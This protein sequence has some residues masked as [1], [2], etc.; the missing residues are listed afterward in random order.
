MNT[1][2]DWLLTRGL[3]ADAAA[4]VAAFA[5]FMAVVAA[6]ALGYFIAKNLVLRLV[7][8]AA[9]RTRTTWDDT[10]IESR[11][12]SRLSHLVP[13]VIIHSGT[14][15]ILV[16]FPRAGS[17]VTTV[18]SVYMGLVGMTVIDALLNAV[19]RIYQTFEV[20]QR[21]QIKTFVQIIK[22]IVYTLGGLAILAIVIG[23]S[24]LVLLSGL[25]AFTAVLLLIFKDAILGFVAGIQLSANNMVQRGDWIAM[26]QYNADGDVIDVSLTTVKVQNWDK[27][28]T[29]IPTYALVSESF[30]NWRGMSES[31]GRRIICPECLVA[32]L[33]AFDGLNT[34]IYKTLGQDDIEIPPPQ[35]VVHLVQP[36]TVSS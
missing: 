6:S 9:Q 13:A 18:A 28:I 29:T 15:I 1:L 36:P 3:E 14:P 21:I 25:G 19:L 23:K 30:K 4:F 24:P 7:R 16:D 11:V 2:K 10:L 20:S 34:A 32:I 35:R 27:T 33:D 26:P 12:F 22:V 31:G 8:A 17:V 5:A